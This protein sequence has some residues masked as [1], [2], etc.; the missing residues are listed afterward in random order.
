MLAANVRAG[1]GQIV[2]EKIGE[3]EPA[4]DFSFNR[5]TVDDQSYFLQVHSQFRRGQDLPSLKKR[6]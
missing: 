5:L 6:G 2:A 3:I 1:Q 4:L